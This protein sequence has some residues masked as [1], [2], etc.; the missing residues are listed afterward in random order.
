MPALTRHLFQ[1]VMTVLVLCLLFAIMS[2][3]CLMCFYCCRRMCGQHKP[4]HAYTRNEQICAFVTLFVGCS[5]IC[6]GVGVGLYSNTVVNTGIEN[7]IYVVNVTM[8]TVMTV[9]PILQDAVADVVVDLNATAETV[10]SEIM[11]VPGSVTDSLAYIVGNTTQSMVA[12]QSEFDEL[13]TGTQEIDAYIQSLTAY[14]TTINNKFAAIMNLVTDLTSTH[15]G[16]PPAYSWQARP[17]CVPDADA[18]N[19]NMTGVVPSVSDVISQL[20]LYNLTHLADNI[21]TQ[22]ATMSTS[23][24]DQLDS[25][26]ASI[27]DSIDEIVATANTTVTEQI[28][29]IAGS[30]VGTLA[31][32]QQMFTIYY[33]QYAAQFLP[34]RDQAMIA[35]FAV[36]TIVILFVML[37]FF[38]RQSMLFS[39]GVNLAWL[40]ISLLWLLCFLHILLTAILGKGCD[41]LVTKDLSPVVPAEFLESEIMT[42]VLG[43]LEECSQP[44]GNIADYFNLTSL[45]DT[46]EMLSQFFNASTI[47][48]A[49]DQI[50]ITSTLG[51][52][53]QLN[54]LDLSE[55]QT[56]MTSLDSQYGAFINLLRDSLVTT[57]NST[58][59]ALR[60]GLVTMQGDSGACMILVSG[61][62]TAADNNYQAT[63]QAIID[64]IDEIVAVDLVNVNGNLTVLETMLSDF[65]TSANASVPVIQNLVDD[66]AS[67]N[68]DLTAIVDGLKTTIT[69]DTLPSVQGQVTDFVDR[70][71]DVVMGFTNCYWIGQTYNSVYVAVC[72]QFVGGMDG[73]FWACGALA[74]FLFVSIFGMVFTAKR[75]ALKYD[76]AFEMPWPKG[77]PGASSTSSFEHSEYE[78][79]EK[80]YNKDGMFG[81]EPP[82]Y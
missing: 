36:P 43:V 67:L 73:V 19:F 75:W 9:P 44:E 11:A 77:M 21:T 60:T 15:S 39:C 48:E 64:D 22:Y 4:D 2:F 16:G 8:S 72:M 65:T 28:D 49:L 24:N 53:D 13:I 57:A 78:M 17:E 68:G 81:T 35:V 74:T 7:T 66:V 70:T 58:T 27:R 1:G 52:L 76:Q 45:F 59:A 23:L 12:T 40:F 5:L 26:L 41:I 14:V 25:S 3:C 42:T 37:G 30:V 79:S 63:I 50:N 38:F 62:A 61:D 18:P 33:E 10:F 80:E 6:V 46:D 29:S 71:M 34:I 56:A 31:E 55:L 54:E 32:G 82:E 51:A 20:T 69:D 47:L